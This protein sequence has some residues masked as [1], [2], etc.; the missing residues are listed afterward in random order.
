MDCPWLQGPKI[1][2][3]SPKSPNLRYLRRSLQW[4]LASWAEEGFWAPCQCRAHATSWIISPDQHSGTLGDLA[5]LAKL[6]IWTGGSVDLDSVGTHHDCGI[7]QPSLRQQRSW[8]SRR[9]SMNPVLGRASYSSLVQSVH[10][11][12]WHLEGGLPQL[13]APEP[14]G[15]VPAP[16]GVSVP[17]T[18]WGHQMWPLGF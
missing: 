2:Y 10:P 6:Y 17:V 12:S 7:H 3:W 14:S 9:G 4:A 8:H 15:M 18:G 5:V 16:G 13:A 1:P 11:R